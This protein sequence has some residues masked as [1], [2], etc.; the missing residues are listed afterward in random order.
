MGLTEIERQRILLRIKKWKKWRKLTSISY[1]PGWLILLWGIYRSVIGMMEEDRVKLLQ[2]E[3]MTA[4]P[5]IIIGFTFH[6]AKLYQVIEKIMND[7]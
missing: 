5:I 1:L 3:I 7:D 6:M 2:G 4:I